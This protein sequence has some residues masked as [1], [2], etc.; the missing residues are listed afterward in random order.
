MG[1]G[2][3]GSAGA[4][5]G[6]VCPQHQALPA[7]LSRGA[8]WQG[9]SLEQGLDWLRWAPSQGGRDLRAVLCTAALSPH[10]HSP[11]RSVCG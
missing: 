5:H 1:A 4:Q 11:V 3:L 9:G 7:G 10:R 8:V 2:V 6:V